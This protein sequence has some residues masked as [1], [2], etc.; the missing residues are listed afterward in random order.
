MQSKT[1]NI[2]H[3]LLAIATIGFSLVLFLAS[4]FFPA[5]NLSNSDV[6]DGFTALLMGWAGFLIGALLGGGFGAMFSEYV[7]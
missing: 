5:Y 1:H 7:Q 4:L 6:V 2:I 3:I